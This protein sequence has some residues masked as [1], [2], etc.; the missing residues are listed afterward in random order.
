[1]GMLFIF[2]TAYFA[3]AFFQ[4]YAAVL[5]AETEEEKKEDTRITKWYLL[6][7]IISFSLTL[8]VHFYNTMIA[9]V[10]CVG[11]AIGYFFRCLRWKYLKQLIIAAL[12]S[13][14]LAV[15]PMA[16]GVAMGNPLQ[17]SL[18]WGMN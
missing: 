12:L 11:I 2:P 14:L 18:Y 10:L 1:M 8:T 6:G 9:G 3:I 7:L 5:K 16:I 15:A 13:V 4:K 17:G